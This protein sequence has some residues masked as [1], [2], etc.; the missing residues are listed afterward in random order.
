MNDLI[1]KKSNLAITRF[2]AREIKFARN[3]FEKAC[4]VMYG[5]KERTRITMIMCFA[6]IGFAFALGEIS[7]NGGFCAI[8]N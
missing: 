6:L 3:C 1:V 5:S 7:A 8:G 4:D 2:V